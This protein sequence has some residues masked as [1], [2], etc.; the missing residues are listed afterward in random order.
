MY[1][2]YLYACIPTHI[3][4]PLLPNKTFCL[5]YAHINVNDDDVDDD[6]EEWEEGINL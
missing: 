6:A 3:V 4:K 2:A 1:H 5:A